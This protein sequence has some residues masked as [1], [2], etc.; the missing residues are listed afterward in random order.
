[1]VRLS[2]EKGRRK[3]EKGRREKEKVDGDSLRQATSCLQTPS[4]CKHRVEGGLLNTKKYK[5]TI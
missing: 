1:M 4:N 3:R 5:L 2:I